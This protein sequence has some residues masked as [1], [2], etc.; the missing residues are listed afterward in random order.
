VLLVERETSP[1]RKGRRVVLTRGTVGT[2]SLVNDGKERRNDNGR[3]AIWWIRSHSEH[4]Q[5]SEAEEEDETEDK[6][7]STE[8]ENLE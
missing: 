4:S 1:S 2:W 3:R 8:A 7:D 6:N 5:S